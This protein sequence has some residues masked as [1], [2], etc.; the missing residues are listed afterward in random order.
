MGTWGTA[1]FSDD[2]ACDLRDEWRDRI[3]EGLSPREATDRLVADYSGTWADS[4][5]APVFWIALAVSQWKTGRL[6]D[7]VRERALEVIESGADLARW[8]EAASRRARERV[9]A[10]TRDQLESPQPAA[11]AIR[12]RAKSSTPYVEGD[13][14]AYRHGD[15]R[16]F[17]LWISGETTDRSGTHSNA[18][19]LDFV[20]DAPPRLEAVIQRPAM[21]R[22]PPPMKDGTKV[23]P[24]PAAFVVLFPD[25][26]KAD[27]VRLL[28]NVAR[29]RSTSP[30]HG[31]WVVRSNVLD[32]EI[33]R[34]L[35]S[36]QWS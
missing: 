16:W 25:R 8:E 6:L 17:V 26:L 15:G 10:K 23:P 20:G 32:T 12:R 22:Y 3:G 36:R 34:V 13:M 18:E 11:K 21:F 31:L 33:D 28:G 4:D 29:P 2:L 27:R 7:D 35:Q 14:L 24:L 1:I 5:E 19:L 9:L 30:G